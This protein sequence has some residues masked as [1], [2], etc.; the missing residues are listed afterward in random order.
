MIN[1]QPSRRF[2]TFGM[3]NKNQEVKMSTLLET[4]EKELNIPR[5]KLI[6]EGMKHFL[7]VELSNLTIEIKKLGRKYGVDSFNG[8][9]KKLENGEISEAESFDDLSKLEYIELEKEKIAK[10]LK[11]VA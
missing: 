11:K 7:E 5:E 3:F 4:V 6:E 10:L 1:A 9:W 8:L 2:E